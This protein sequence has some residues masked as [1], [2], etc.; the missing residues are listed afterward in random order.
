MVQQFIGSNNFLEDLKE[1]R[2]TFLLAGSVTKTCEIE[3]ITQA[4]IPGLI[5]LT[6]TL[7]GEFVDSGK[8][9]SL[10]D[11]ATTPTGVPTPAIITRAMRELVGFDFEMLDIGLRTT[12]QVDLLYNFDIKESESINKKAGIDAQEL[13]QKGENFAHT[14]ETKPL[15][16]LGESTPAGTTTAYATAKVLGY[17]SEGYFSSSFLKR[18]D[19]LKERIVKE[20]LIL[21]QD[22]P[23]L[24]QLGC[25]SDNMLLFC[26]GFV[27]AYSHKSKIALAGG[28]QMAAVLLIIDALK[29]PIK[30][31]NIALMTT[32]WVYE[33]VHS[34]IEGLLKQLH[35]PID[36]YYANFSF[37]KAH[38][39]ILKRYDE[40][41]AKEGVGAGGALCYAFAQGYSQEEILESI[42]KVLTR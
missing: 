13:I 33:D 1:K 24:E 38:I 40:G 39:P 21:A 20:A 8:L 32:K 9:H 27:S 22:K 12:P 7:D 35:F 15:V 2:A 10:K 29:L 18:P 41:E 25:V 37:A 23:L 30:S 19:N 36:A 26:A 34:N 17:A 31:E 5:P 14:Y 11:I 4:G 28:T 3:G 16:I 42:E 6:P